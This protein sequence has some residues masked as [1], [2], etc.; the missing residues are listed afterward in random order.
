MPLPD[1]LTDRWRQRL[2]EALERLRE[3]ARAQGDASEPAHWAPGEF[4]ARIVQAEGHAVRLVIEIPIHEL[5]QNGVVGL[6]ADNDL[7]PAASRAFWDVED[8]LAERHER[9]RDLEA[10]AP[11]DDVRIEALRREVDAL[12]RRQIELLDGALAA[13]RAALPERDRI[14]DVLARHGIDLPES[15]LGAR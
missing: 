14:G 6:V 5:K 15:L 3:E 7:P 2:E 9:L 4:E 10:G 12:E 1:I 13:Q 8:A 11:H